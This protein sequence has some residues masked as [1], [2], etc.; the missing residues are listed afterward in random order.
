VRGARPGRGVDPGQ[1]AGGDQH[2]DREAE[3]G[4]AERDVQGQDAGVTEAELE[5]LGEQQ[6]QVGKGRPAWTAAASSAARR[7]RAYA[8]ARSRRRRLRR[9]A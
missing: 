9:R 5:L 2:R 8:L 7:L 6:R 4:D 1:P 3:D